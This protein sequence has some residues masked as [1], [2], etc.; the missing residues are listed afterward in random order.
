MVRLANRKDAPPRGSFHDLARRVDRYFP[1][2]E[3]RHAP[4]ARD[5]APDD[6]GDDD[7]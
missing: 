4:R 6:D 2:L 7:A 3:V 5:E 1:P